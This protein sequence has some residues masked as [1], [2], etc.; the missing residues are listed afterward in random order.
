MNGFRKHSRSDSSNSIST[1]STDLSRSPSRS[2]TGDVHTGQSQLLSKIGLGRKR[3]RSLST[4]PSYTSDSSHDASR[5]GP[6][7]GSDGDR[8][9][10]RGSTIHISNSVGKRDERRR[11]PPLSESASCTSY[12]SIDE[13][14]RKSSRGT[15][16]SKRRRHS[17]RSPIARGR[18]RAEFN[19]RGSR[20]TRSPSESRDRGEVVRNRISMT[21]NL[22]GQGDGSRRQEHRLPVERDDNY[23]KDN[24]R[25]GRSA[26][27]RDG[28]TRSDRQ[29]A[30]ARPPRTARSL[31][32]FSKR[33]ALTQ[34]MNLGH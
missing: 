10:Q 20:R 34:A 4:S 2:R 11:K 12:S 6:L 29:S 8:G 19:K 14:R 33:L 24:D 1:I 13:E 27:D 26:R 32:P 15:D 22:P 5:R 21:P 16:R 3:R 31:S 17:S 28:N 25:Y 18:E 7:R 23:S 30:I 9:R